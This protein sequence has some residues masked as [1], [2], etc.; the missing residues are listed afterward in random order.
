MGVV[1]FLTEFERSP[2]LKLFDAQ[3]S[4]RWGDIGAR[5][6]AT[7]TETGYLVYVDGGYI[8][9]VEGYTYSGEKWPTQVESIEWYEL[10]EGAELQ[11]SPKVRKP[12][13]G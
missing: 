11:N 9:A 12:N 3:A 2:E 6:N 4:L 13:Q 7:R 5:L 1:G 8:T 10:K